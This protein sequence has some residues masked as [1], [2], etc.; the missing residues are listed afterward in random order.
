MHWISHAIALMSFSEYAL[1]HSIYC[2]AISLWICIGSAMVFSRCLSLDKQWVSHC[3]AFSV[4]E[5]DQ[6]QYC[7]DVFLWIGIGSVIV[8]SCC[9]YLDMHWFSQWAL[10]SLSGYALN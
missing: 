10:L 3:I 4:Y 2:L 9:L 7:L 6:P 8:L 5:M 1:H